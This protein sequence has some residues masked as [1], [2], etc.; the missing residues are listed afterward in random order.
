MR[1]TGADNTHRE[2]KRCLEGP[3]AI[4]QKGTNCIASRV[5]HDQVGFAIA[6]KV[7]DS[8]V[9]SA[10]VCRVV[11]GRLERTITIAQQNTD[12]A[13]IFIGHG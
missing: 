4:P 7:S 8:D 11:D 5:D 2:V 12:V 13:H 10:G 9:R 6:V 3:V 1:R